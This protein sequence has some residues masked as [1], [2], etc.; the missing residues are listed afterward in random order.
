MLLGMAPLRI[1]FQ[2]GG[3]DLEE[4]HNEYVG[5]TISSTID[6]YTFVTAK[7]RKDK[8]FQGFSPDFA[9]HIPPKHYKKIQAMQGHE[10]VLACIEELNF[11]KGIDI[12]FCSDVGPGSGL[13]ASSSLTAN[14]VKVILELKKEKWDKHKIALAAYRIGHD[15]LKWGIGKQDE[16][17][18]VYGGLNLY[19]FTKEKVTVEPIPLNYASRREMQNNSMLFYL[20]GRKHSSEILNSQLNDMRKSSKITM[21]ALHD[22]KNLALQMRDALR[23]NDL[24]QFSEIIKQGWEVKKRYT[25]GISNPFIDRIVDKGYSLGAS[26]MKVTGAGGGGHL[27]VYAEPSRHMMIEKEFKKMGVQKVSFNFQNTGATVLDL[28]NL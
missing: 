27:Y 2:G 19:K 10:I 26:S 13:G 21:S 6:K 4:Y 11:S 28:H 23:E 17:A 8:N 16:F 20:G 7:L 22:A 25:K 12:F 3:T 14:L 24:T 15:V 18:A 5:Y 1:S 9:S